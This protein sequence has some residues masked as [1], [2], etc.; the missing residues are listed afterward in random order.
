M[1]VILALLAAVAPPAT[2][3]L[4]YFHTGDA[5]EER[6]ALD[7]VVREGAWPGPPDRRVD[8]TNLGR[9]LFEVRDAKGGDTL[10]SRGFAS[11]FDSIS[12]FSIDTVPTSTGC[13][14]WWQSRISS[15]TAVHFSAAVR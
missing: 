9:Y 15:T 4:D 1:L 3:R 2:I 11:I 5:R 6:Y 12:L 10:Y 7:A 14:R 8:D 13:P